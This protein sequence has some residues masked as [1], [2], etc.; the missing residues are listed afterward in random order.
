MGTTTR[1]RHPGGVLLLPDQDIE[2]I[3]TGNEEPGQNGNF[4]M[5][6]VAGK[7]EIQKR[8]SNAWATLNRLS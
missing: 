7:R 5:R 1:V 2:Q 3:A 4:R 6:I 8:I